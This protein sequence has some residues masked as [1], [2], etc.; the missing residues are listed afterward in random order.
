[1]IEGKKEKR[2]NIE[3]SPSEERA[4][5]MRYETGAFRLVTAF[6]DG[7]HFTE[8]RSSSSVS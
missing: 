6:R 1:M 3:T 7:N 2:K 8:P 4:S 5:R